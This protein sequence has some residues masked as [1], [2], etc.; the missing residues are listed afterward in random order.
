CGVGV[1]V[2]LRERRCLRE[3]KPGELAP[4]LRVLGLD[5]RVRLESGD[6]GVRVALRLVRGRELAIARR[7]V[8]ML[9]DVLLRLRDGVA[10][11]AAEDV[12]VREELVE[13]ARAGADAEEGEREGEEGGEQDGHELRPAPPLHAQQTPGRISPGAVL[14]A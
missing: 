9:L 1:L 2:G 14:T 5:P 4:R 10:A 7:G 12:E 11:A 6:R 8:R 3:L 13:T